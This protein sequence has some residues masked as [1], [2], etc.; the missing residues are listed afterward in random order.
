MPRRPKEWGAVNEMCLPTSCCPVPARLPK[1]SPSCRRSPQIH[2]HCADPETATHR[3][4]G[5]R[6]RARIGG[7]QRRRCPRGP[8]EHTPKPGLGDAAVTITRTG[9]MRELAGGGAAGAF[10]RPQ[11]FPN[12]VSAYCSFGARDIAALIPSNA[13]PYPTPSSTMRRSFLGQRNARVS[14]GERRRA[15][16]AF[17]NL[18]GHGQAACRQGTI[19]LTD[20]P[21]LGRLGIELLAGEDEVAAPYRADHFLPQQ[22]DASRARCKFEVWRILKNRRRSGQDNIGEQDVFGVQPYRAV[23]RSNE[24]HFD[25]EDVHEDFFAF[26]D[27]FCRNLRGKKSKPSGLIGLH[28]GPAGAGQNHNAIVRVGTDGVKEIGQIVH[29][30]AHQRTSVP[31][32][33]AAPLPA[34]HFSSVPGGRCGSCRGRLLSGTW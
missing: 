33:C 7:Y 9:S 19:S 20:A 1:G 18:R 5:R 23:H 13:S 29:E 6:I 12:R 22:M 28:E 2:A 32:Q 16:R 17:G 8:N 30:R 31:R 26:R 11:R 27:R 21:F 34:H 25:V 4:R 10:Y 14:C 3:R 15:W 24:R